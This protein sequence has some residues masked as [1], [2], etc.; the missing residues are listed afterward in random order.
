MTMV[1]SV[2]VEDERKSSLKGSAVDVDVELEAPDH[3][4]SPASKESTLVEPKD[5]L[6]AEREATRA[7]IHDPEDA[8]KSPFDDFPDGGLRAW[9]CLMGVC[10]SIFFSMIYC[11]LTNHIYSAS[12]SPRQGDR[13]TSLIFLLG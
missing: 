13:T 1:A 8:E 2:D 6:E 9:L 10:T 4:R 3:S 11:A 5:L 12:A 7:A